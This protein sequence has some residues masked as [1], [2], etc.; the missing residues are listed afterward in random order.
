MTLGQKE[1]FTAHHKSACPLIDKLLEGRFDFAGMT[2]I[3]NDQARA[4][5]ACRFLY[6]RPFSGGLGKYWP[7]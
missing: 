6:G 3:Q 1:R 5:G 7:G 2:R 4:E